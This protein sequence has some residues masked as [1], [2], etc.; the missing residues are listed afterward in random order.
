MFLAALISVL[1]PPEQQFMRGFLF[2]GIKEGYYAVAIAYTACTS[3]CP[4]VKRHLEVI[5]EKLS[6]NGMALPVY[7]V[8][9]DPKHDTPKKR[10]KFL[11][12]FPAGSDWSFLITEETKTRELL[13]ELKMGF[14][15]NRGNGHAMH[16]MTLAILNQQMTR[17]AF[18][19]CLKISSSSVDLRLTRK[20]SAFLTLQSVR[21]GALRRSR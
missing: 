19:S 7:F 16:T 12:N 5:N 21:A 11:K 2:S 10:K 9:L 8:S 3:V 15:D 18:A 1:I 14:S 6:K 20:T 17:I 13:A 4:M